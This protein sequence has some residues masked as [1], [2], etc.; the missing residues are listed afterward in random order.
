MLSF[1]MFFC[2][3]FLSFSDLGGG[4]KRRGAYTSCY[5]WWWWWCLSLNHFFGSNTQHTIMLDKWS[6]VLPI[7]MVK[8]KYTHRHTTDK[9]VYVV[10]FAR[11]KKTNDFFSLNL[12][13]FFLW[14][15]FNL[16]VVVRSNVHHKHTH[17]HSFHL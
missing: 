10:L 17:G 4:E 6:Q 1:D 9:E 11:E 7:L 5:W 3:C 12:F 16:V 8:K 13:S 14:S 15:G 2:C